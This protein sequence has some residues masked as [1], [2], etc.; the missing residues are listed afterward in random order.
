MRQIL[1]YRTVQGAIRAL[2]NGGR[3]YNLLTRAG[4][5]VIDSG[6]LARA[7]GVYSSDARA[8]LYFEMAL[9][10]LSEEQEEEVISLLTPDLKRRLEAKRARVLQPSVVES[11]G[12]AGNSTIVTGYPVYVENQTQFQGFMV[13]VVH[14]AVVLIPIMDQFDV[15]EVYDTPERIEPRT[16]I[17]T[18]RGSKRLDGTYSRFGGVLKELYFEDKTGKEHG[19][20]LE[21]MYYTPLE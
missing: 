9:M 13:L 1:P 4:D 20:Y 7:A 5:D 3:F 14:P 12:I 15:Y 10:A 19:L 2:D 21:A 6:E 17:A 8:F 16:V 11:E 18:V